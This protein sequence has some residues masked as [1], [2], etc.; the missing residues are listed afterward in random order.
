MK[1]FIVLLLTCAFGISVVLIAQT[2]AVKDV[3]QQKTQVLAPKDKSNKAT[4]QPVKKV[5]SKKQKTVHVKP[6]D[7]KNTAVSPESTGKK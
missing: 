3:T 4:A 6:V 5:P 1:K 7:K 2:P